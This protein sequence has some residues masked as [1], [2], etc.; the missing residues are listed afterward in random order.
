MR[1]IWCAAS[2][3]NC[4]RALS[5]FL[6]GTPW[7][8]TSDHSERA[9]E[10]VCQPTLTSRGC[11]QE[12]LWFCS[13]S[14]HLP[15]IQSTISR[16]IWCSGIVI[17][18]R[19]HGS[20]AR[21]NIEIQFVRFVPPRPHG[22]ADDHG[23]RSPELGN[24]YF[25]NTFH[26]LAKTSRVAHTQVCERRVLGVCRQWVIRK[27]QR[28]EGSSASWSQFPTSL[29][30]KAPEKQKQ[31][32]DP[33]KQHQRSHPATPAHRHITRARQYTRGRA[34]Q[35]DPPPAARH[36]P[37]TTAAGSLPSPALS[38]AKRTDRH[39]TSCLA[40]RCPPVTHPLAARRRT[41]PT[42]RL[43]ALLPTRPDRRTGRTNRRTVQSTEIAHPRQ[44]Q[45]KRRPS[46]AV[47]LPL[48]HCSAV[49]PPQRR[50][51]ARRDWRPTPSSAARRHPS[52]SAKARPRPPALCQR[53]PRPTKV[54][55]HALRVRRGPACPRSPHLESS[56]TCITTPA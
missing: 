17:I 48:A 9:Q 56:H 41:R 15:W 16:C 25:D 30:P 34:S 26:Q 3:T 50:Q 39:R 49:H 18:E 33:R 32:H 21:T 55:S 43:T 53:P 29:F 11:G 44:P 45:R 51:N 8:G 2:L 47:C 14:V 13:P 42:A 36:Q 31:K 24:S 5:F 23:T 20:R 38:P 35:R 1:L 46:A 19:P 40:V 28:F 37:P 4:H 12:A 7:S 52:S 27:R 22:C 6:L 54:R 10:L